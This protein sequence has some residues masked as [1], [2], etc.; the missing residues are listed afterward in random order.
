MY[1]YLTFSFNPAVHHKSLKYCLNLQKYFRLCF[2]VEALW[3]TRADVVALID[4]RS[5][6]KSNPVYRCLAPHQHTLA[7]IWI[8]QEQLTTNKSNVKGKKSVYIANLQ[9]KV[10][11]LLL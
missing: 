7:I 5:Q 4:L 8:S 10:P 1:A 6:I 11:T 2:R 3:D 9:L